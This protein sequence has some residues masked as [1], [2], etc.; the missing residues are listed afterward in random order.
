MAE[1]RP[2]LLQPLYLAL[3]LAHPAS[4]RY[5]CPVKR[6]EIVRLVRS[7][8]RLVAIL[9]TM[10]ATALAPAGSKEPPAIIAVADL[11]GDYD[12]FTA[13]LK[14]ADLINAKG[15]WVG[16][17]AVLVQLGD[18][19][20][21]GPDTRKMIEHLKKLEKQAKRKGGRVVALIGNHEAM[22]VTG[23]LRYVTPEEFAAFADSKS[24]KL[25][26]AHF[27]LNAEAL[28]VYYRKKDPALTDDDVRA[29]FDAE[30]PLGYIEHRLA[31]SPHGEIG[32]WVASHDAITKVGDTLFVHGGISAAYASFPMTKINTDVRDALNARGGP[33]LEDD[34]GPLWYRGLASETPE[35]EI[36]VAA[37]LAAYDA[38]RIVIGHT[39]HKEGVKSYYGGRVIAADT[40]ASKAYGGIR[41]FIRIDDNGVTAVEN[42]VARTVGGDGQ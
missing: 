2:F 20:D 29:A 4:A 37:A 31:W 23:D 10:L 27:K 21:R 33:I 24:E 13:I 22:N 9:L 25:R 26:T 30:F 35:G 34:A 41:S 39:P 28:S 17:D 1:T 6:E 3:Y 18:L 11:H 16:G 12:A 40:G 14:S 8:W 19:P 42:G 36:D 15:D 32:K 7:P 38:K 5:L